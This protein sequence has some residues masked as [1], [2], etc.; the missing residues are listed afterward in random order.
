ML[1]RSM[2]QA[3]YTPHNNG[4]F[5]LAYE[6]YSHFT[7]PI[8]RYPDLLAHRA[9]KAILKEEQYSLPSGHTF[10]PRPGVR[11][12]PP[13]KEGAKN[14]K[15]PAQST[16]N[17]TPKD[18]KKWEA[19]GMHCSA[20]ERRADEAS[21]DV[22]AWLKCTYMQGHLGEVMSGTVSA[23]TGFGIFVT[24]DQV[25]VEGLVHITELGGEYFRF[26]EA[27]QELRGE[28]SGM[29]YSIGT[30]VVVQVAKVDLEGRRIDLALVPND[31]LI[32]S[33]M[34]PNTASK[35]AT[36]TG[37]KNP[38]EGHQ[39]GGNGNGKHFGQG[40]QA[41]SAKSASPSSSGSKKASSAKKSK[42]QT[43]FLVDAP[44]PFVSPVQAARKGKA[45]QANKRSGHSGAAHS[46][47][48]HPNLNVNA[49]AGSKSKPVGNA[50][51]IAKAKANAKASAKASAKANSKA[52]AKAGTVVKE[53]SKS[54]T[55]GSK[56][57]R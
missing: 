30:K 5:G 8:R 26:D 21:R 40:N 22:E 23:A 6:A 13:A 50:N 24:L 3:V 29:R 18:L 49:N 54:L 19:V 32:G 28:R 41:Y 43:N 14:A 4:H 34:A 39:N 57:R 15:A 31:A 20:N 47:S 35:T 10:S 7:S 46:A 37:I 44:G 11:Q 38:Q 1:L 33:T 55:S 51:P 2:Q 53:P 48:T 56:K 16:A 27:R 12:R 45:A 36:K 17:A 25:S 52:S 42:N 9:I